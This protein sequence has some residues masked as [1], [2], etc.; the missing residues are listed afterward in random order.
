LALAMPTACALAAPAIAAL[1]I[2]VGSSACSE[3]GRNDS[4]EPSELDSAAEALAGHPE[5]A[6]IDDAP[7][8][9]PSPASDDETD[10]SSD[11]F[12]G[13]FDGDADA[14]H[15]PLCL[16]LS[17]PDRP[18]KVLDLS[19]D[20]RNG[21]LTLVAGDCRVAGLLPGTS[22]AFADWSNRLYDWNLDFWGCTDHAPTGIA[23]VPADVTGLTS[24]DVA[25][26]IDDYLIAATSTLRLS[27]SE[28]SDMRQN[29]VDLATD[30]TS[31]SDDHPVSVCGASDAATGNDGIV[32]VEETGSE[33]PLITDASSSNVDVVGD[34]E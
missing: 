13:A 19:A 17:D 8:A 18:V 14:H 29:L 3:D 10:A 28:A 21:Y 4:S 1:V 33:A 26:L 34:G 22:A 31:E 32:D 24:A 6:A 9:S 27:S 12:E 7:D 30:V 2:A 16:R 25:L 11:S 23:L 20:V 15:F 5:D